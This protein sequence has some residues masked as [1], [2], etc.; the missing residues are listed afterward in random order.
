MS[1]YHSVEFLVHF[2]HKTKFVYIFYSTENCAVEK[3]LFSLKFN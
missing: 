1:K 3:L 2:R